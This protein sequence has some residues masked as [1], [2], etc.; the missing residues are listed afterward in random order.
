MVAV[1][2]IRI[3]KQKSETHI[4][5]EKLSKDE[6]EIVAI[7]YAM[8]WMILA[9]RLLSANPRSPNVHVNWKYTNEYTVSGACDWRDWQRSGCEYVFFFFFKLHESRRV[10]EKK[11]KKKKRK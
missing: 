3:Q 1:G 4:K 11:K 8:R 7:L 5:I 10:E 2:I 9:E 6:I